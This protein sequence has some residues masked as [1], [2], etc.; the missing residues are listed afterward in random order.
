MTERPCPQT[1]LDARPTA[2]RN[3]LPFVAIFEDNRVVTIIPPQERNVPV[4]LAR[5]QLIQ[6]ETA[7]LLCRDDTVKGLFFYTNLFRLV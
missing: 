4:V 7:G 3:N 2:Y 5:E 1:Q 6:A